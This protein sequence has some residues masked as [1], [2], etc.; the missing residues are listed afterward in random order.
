MIE[1]RAIKWTRMSLSYLVIV[2]LIGLVLRVKLAVIFP[3]FNF[4]YILHAHSHTAMLGWIYSA[5]Y[6]ALLYNYLPHKGFTGKVYNRLFILTQVSIAG[7]LITFSI[8]GYGAFS[9]AFSTLH[10][11]FSYLFVYF[12]V[13]DTR[14]TRI[15]GKVPPSLKFVYSGL[16]FLVVSSFGP[17]TLAVLAANKL[18]G[19][20]I[21]TQAVY[22]YLHF[23]YN[24]F[25]TFAIIGLWLRISERSGRYLTGRSQQWGYYLLFVSAFPAYF[26]SLLG[27]DIYNFLKITGI[28]SGIIQLAAVLA[29]APGLKRSLK[30]SDY[31]SGGTDRILFSVSF[32]SLLAKFILQALSSVPVFTNAVFVFR[33][34]VMGYLHLV[35]LG[36]VT[37]GII[38]WFGTSH[39]MELAS[40]FSRSS[41][42]VFLAGFALSEVLLFMQILITLIDLSVIPYHALLLGSS[43]LM[44][45]GISALW[46]KQLK[47]RGRR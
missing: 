42:M 31:E 26:L 35:L 10:I 3:L 4:R 39:F 37:C 29:I 16:L 18:T 15:E 9:I 25:F 24:G 21:Y 40:R 23:L 19:S 43:A 22:F 33:D 36:F 32:Y 13:R 1:D 44:F 17:W 34:L 11:I 47:L 27:F 8:Q 12:F 5:V 38:S 28:I 14:K 20:E 41:V 7:M 2:A 30:N 46:I 45:A 6:I